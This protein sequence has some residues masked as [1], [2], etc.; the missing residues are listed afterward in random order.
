MFW[1]FKSSDAFGKNVMV[2]VAKNLQVLLAAKYELKP[3]FAIV[4][5]VVFALCD[6]SFFKL[7]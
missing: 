1:V 2:E 3:N 4:R 6:S 5:A 7:T